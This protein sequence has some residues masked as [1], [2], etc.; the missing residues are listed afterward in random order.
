[1]AVVESMLDVHILTKNDSDIPRMTPVMLRMTDCRQE[2]W[3]YLAA[4]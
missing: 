2:E 4:L 1:M 3:R